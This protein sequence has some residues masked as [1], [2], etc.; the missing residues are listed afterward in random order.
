MTITPGTLTVEGDAVVLRPP[1]GFNSID[2]VRLSSYCDSAV[3]VAN[4]LGTDQNLQYLQPNQQ[5]VYPVS[6]VGRTPK[7]MP[8]GADTFA[9][10]LANVTVEWSTD[11]GNDFPGVYPT[12]IS[13]PAQV[14]AE[15]IFAK[16]VPNT[17]VVDNLGTQT[18]AHLG[19]GAKIDIHKYASLILI[20]D[21]II[22]PPIVIDYEIQ[23]SDANTV[24]VG[25]ITSMDD[26]IGVWE[27]PVRGQTIFFFNASVDPIELTLE[28]T[29][30]VVPYERRVTEND[31]IYIPINFTGAP[32][33]AGTT[34]AATP[35]QASG[36]AYV[37]LSISNATI[38]GSIVL[39]DGLGNQMNI[40]NSNDCV[41]LGGS[42]TGRRLMYLP[43]SITS[44]AFTCLVG[45]AGTLAVRVI[46]LPY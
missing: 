41:A 43:Q 28:G 38:T 25:T 40:I 8:T 42:A 33:I 23:D 2:G 31:N 34:Y 36:P 1:G 30:R 18:I 37:E 16:G 21:G 26:Q 15:A 3:L 13:P 10:I 9:T 45:G 46:S 7:L 4:L 24:V 17:F 6:N 14:I 44:I 5:N 35:L 11:P 20:Q 22:T 19:T 27:I 32:F 39:T 12:Q 29:N